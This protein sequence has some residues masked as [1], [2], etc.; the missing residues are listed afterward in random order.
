MRLLH[1]E[2]TLRR[3]EERNEEYP[4]WTDV[5]YRHDGFETPEELWDMLKTLRRLGAAM[6]L[7]QFGVSA[8]LTRR[9]EEACREIDAAFGPRGAA[10]G[11][12]TKPV[13]AV[14]DEAISS[15]QMEGATTTRRVALEMLGKG[16][17]PRDKSETMIVNNFAAMDFI[18]GNMA[19][20]LTPELIRALHAVI[21]AGTLDEAQC[22]G[23]FRTNDDIV[24]ADAITGEIV[25]RPP[26]AGEV[27]AWVESLCA[28]VNGVAGPYV[29]PVIRAIVAHYVVAF[30]HP[31]VDGNGRTARAVFYWSMLKSG[32]RPMQYVSISAEIAKSKKAYER[33][34]LQSEADGG[35]V[36]YFIV[37]HLKVLKRAYDRLRAYA[38]AVASERRAAETLANLNERQVALLAKMRTDGL[39]AVSV[40]NVE[41]WFGVSHTT[42]KADLDALHEMSMVE[43]RKVNK[44]KSVYIL[45]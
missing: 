19:E 7:P 10:V 31:F 24:V 44:V 43:R 1:D 18:V 20:A 23:R 37:Y 32:Y 36:G 30:V 26:P 34:F 13:A 39:E 33:A 15:S 21:T 27:E 4:Y 9:M 25:H 16:R 8:L 12:V 22:E 38:D 3:V 6:R 40:R 42:A 29:H 5:K 45:K 17:K 14:M 35:D 28:F 2:R 11:G 41:V